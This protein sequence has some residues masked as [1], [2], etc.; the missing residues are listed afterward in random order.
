MSAVSDPEKKLEVFIRNHLSYFIRNLVEMKVLSHEY[1]CLK[2]EYHQGI[3]DLRR[4]Y[5]LE[6]ETTA[7]QR[8]SRPPL[9][10]GGFYSFDVQ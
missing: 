6:A 5:Y 9:A 1:E 2:G 4:D 8:E 3:A 10:P 7:G